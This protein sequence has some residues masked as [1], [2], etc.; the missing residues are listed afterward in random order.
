MTGSTLSTTSLSGMM[1]SMAFR[2]W[3]WLLTSISSSFL[4]P[5]LCSRGP[6]GF[7]LIRPWRWPVRVEVVRPRPPL[8]QASSSRILTIRA[9]EL[10][11]AP[12]RKSHS[13]RCLGLWRS[14]F[15]LVTGW[16]ETLSTSTVW[17]LPVEVDYAS[18]FP[19]TFD[20]TNCF[21]GQSAM[22]LTGRDLDG[23]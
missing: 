22:R 2:S 3:S 17:R 15:R 12:V 8:C 5:S 7:L 16:C 11:V 1:G 13:V 23:Q 10:P 18:R 20:L 9:T 19:D 4:A 14:N 6:E 21:I